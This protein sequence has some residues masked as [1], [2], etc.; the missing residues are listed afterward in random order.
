L[1]ILPSQSPSWRV[2]TFLASFLMVDGYG[3]NGFAYQKAAINAELVASANTG[4]RVVRLKGGDPFVFGR[5]RGECEALTAAGHPYQ[6]LPGVS[7]T[8]AAPLLAGVPLTDPVSGASSFAVFS[9]ADTKGQLASGKWDNVGSAADTL[10]FLMAVSVSFFFLSKKEHTLQAVAQ[11]IYGYIKD[12]IFYYSTFH[13]ITRSPTFV[14][15]TFV[16]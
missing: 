16:C 7:S 4:A 1:Y 12:L 14:R 11:K 8:L 3:R 2:L 10:I 9:G 5:S 15:L 6:V 13:F